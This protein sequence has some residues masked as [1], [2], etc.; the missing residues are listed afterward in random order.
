MI[1]NYET[2]EHLSNNSGCISI[3]QRHY[4]D[5]SK[6]SLEKHKLDPFFSNNFLLTNLYS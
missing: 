1:E 5:F 2:S 6:I 3:L 4:P